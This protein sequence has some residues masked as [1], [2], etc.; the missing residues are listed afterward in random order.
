MSDPLILGLMLASL[1]GPETAPAEAF[2]ESNVER[3]LALA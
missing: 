3:I 1:A 2:E